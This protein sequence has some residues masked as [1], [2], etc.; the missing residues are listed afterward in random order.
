MRIAVNTRLLLDGRLEGIGWFTNEIFSRITKSHP[1]HE[2]IFLFDRPFSEKFIFSSN[3]KPVVIYPPSR[4]PFLWYLWFEISVP[5]ALKKYNA[6]LFISPDAY[7]SIS[8]KVPSI[9]VIHDINFE[10]Y[11][12]DMSWLYRNY[13]RFFTPRFVNKAN[14]IITVSEYSKNDICETYSLTPEKVSVVYNGS[15]PIY[16]PISQEEKLLVK[17]KYTNGCDYFIYIGALLPRKNLARLLQAFDKFKEEIVSDVKLLIIGEKMFKTADIENAFRL[18]KFKND[19]IFAGRLYPG[20]IEKAMGAALA[21]TYVSYFEGFGLPIV[22]A[23]NCNVPVITSN[24][25]SMPEVAGDAALLIDPFSVESIKN[26]LSEIY[27]N[28]RLREELITKGSERKKLFNW[29]IS[30]N[31]FWKIIEKHL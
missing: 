30:A 14:H 22:E 21:L 20:Q 9:C 19:V 7:T 23:M 31:K 6:D 26:A 13:Y 16:K 2:F 4:H 12:E 24:V 29:D 10:H 8:T 18:M 28:Q 25:T 11:P 17:K 5:Y 3:I 27:L 15:N 1:E